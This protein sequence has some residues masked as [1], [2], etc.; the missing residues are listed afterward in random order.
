VGRHVL[1]AEV[2]SALWALT[3]E[4]ARGQVREAQAVAVDAAIG[5]LTAH[6]CVRPSRP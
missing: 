2:D 6:A 1:A 3:L 4:D 5:Y